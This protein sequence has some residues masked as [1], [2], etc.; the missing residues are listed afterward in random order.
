METINVQL[1]LQHC[2]KTSWNAMLHILLPTNQPGLATNQ[3]V[4]NLICR[5]GLNVGGK[6]HNI[7]TIAKLKE[8]FLPLSL[9]KDLLGKICD[10]ICVLT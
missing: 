5:T 3:V 4:V 2:C 1:V 6:T 9:L 10:F 8:G 7:A